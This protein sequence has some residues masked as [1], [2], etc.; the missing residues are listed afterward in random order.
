MEDSG[1][2]WRRELH[3][4]LFVDVTAWILEILVVLLHGI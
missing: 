3:E 4:L 1:L 2:V